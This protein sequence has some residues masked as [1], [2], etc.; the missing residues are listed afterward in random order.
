D[1][2]VAEMGNNWPAMSDLTLCHAPHVKRD[3][4]VDFSILSSFAKSFPNL[5][6]L[7]LFFGKEVLPFDGDLYPDHRF[8][9]LKTLGVGL[10]PIPRSGTRDIGFLLAS[11]CQ[12]PP[13]VE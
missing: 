11:L 3:L 13:S 8:R 10:S 5:Q 2:D 7:R 9:M 1:E 4:G 6:E 12:S